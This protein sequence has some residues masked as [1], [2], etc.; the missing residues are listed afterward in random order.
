MIIIKI[1]YQGAMYSNSFFIAKRFVLENELK[2]YEFIPLINSKNVYEALIKEKIDYGVMA[3]CNTLGG[4]VI[5]TKDVLEKKELV[6]IDL[7]NRKINHCLFKKSKNDEI[8][9]IASHI[10]A[11]NQSKNIRKEKYPD[12]G[13]IVTNDTALAAEQLKEGILDAKIGVL[14]T[15]EAG[16]NNGLYLISETFQDNLENITTFGVFKKINK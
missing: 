8:T 16:I 3:I 9:S 15:M 7:Y 2:D 14:C 13:E 6:V 4:E 10:Q 1:G 12:L 5:E 11:L